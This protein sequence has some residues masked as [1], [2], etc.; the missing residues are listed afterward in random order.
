MMMQMLYSMAT[1]PENIVQLLM[2]Q[3]AAL[4]MKN[5]VRIGEAIYVMLY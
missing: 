4:N 5:E 3:G 1:L 2:E